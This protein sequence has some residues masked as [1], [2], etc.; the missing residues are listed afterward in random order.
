MRTRG[1]PTN[2]SNKMTKPY[3]IAVFAFFGLIVMH[4]TRALPDSRAA[5]AD[6]RERQDPV[7]VDE[8]L[9]PCGPVFFRLMSWEIAGEHKSC[10][11][12]IATVL[13]RAD[14][15][16]LVID[17]HRDSVEP[18]SISGARARVTRRYLVKAKGI[19]P[20]RLVLRDFSD[21]C[22]H[23][24]SI[25]DLNRRVEFWYLRDAT[26]IDSL[27]EPCAPG[28]KPTFKRRD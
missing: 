16:Y 1:E 9:N 25:Q 28:A 2:N 4:S 6:T 7:V 26:G 18:R 15:Y 19:D 20:G 3:F 12:E 11:D 14:N 23:E 24:S 5:P 22:P 10:F 17:G 13:K 8:I 27:P 21:T